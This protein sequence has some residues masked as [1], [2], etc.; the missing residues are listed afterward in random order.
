MDRLA[1]EGIDAGSVLHR[2]GAT[3]RTTVFVT[4]DARERAGHLGSQRAQSQGLRC[5]ERG[6]SRRTR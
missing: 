1:L 4:P 5:R 2:G 3:D 6:R